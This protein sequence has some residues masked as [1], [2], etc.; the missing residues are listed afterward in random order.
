MMRTY[1]TTERYSIVSKTSV[2]E[3]TVYGVEGLYRI[4]AHFH[5]GPAW[6]PEPVMGKIQDSLVFLDSSANPLN[7]CQD[8][9][10][11]IDGKS[12]ILFGKVTLDSAPHAHLA[13][14]GLTAPLKIIGE[15]STVYDMVNGN[16]EIITLMKS[17]TIFAAGLGLLKSEYAS[18]GVSKHTDLTGYAHAGDTLGH[19]DTDDRF[20]NQV[21]LF[22]PSRPALTGAGIHGPYRRVFRF[23]T[24]AK[25]FVD[26]LG[27]W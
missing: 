25:V 18:I 3:R 2:G 1:D 27:R 4:D 19:I 16:P 11:P 23:Q 21:S 8:E 9:L 5:L 22:S 14:Q 24:P 17:K 6:E 13:I 7:A 10:I 12:G 26:A 15:D 20:T